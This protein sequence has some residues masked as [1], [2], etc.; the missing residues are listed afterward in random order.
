[1]AYSEEALAFSQIPTKDQI[2]V[3]D[4]ISFLYLEYC[5]IRQDRTG[6]VAIGRDYEDI[7]SHTTDIPPAARIQLPV[8]GLGVLLLGPGTSISN[9]AATSC[10]RSG[11]SIMFTSGG[12]I[13]C[14]SLGTP[15]TSSAKWA[16]AQAKLIANEARARDAA[17]IL[18]RKQLGIA[19]MNVDSIAAM[20]GIE[21][22]TIR[23]LYK[24]LAS[25]HK[26]KRFKRDTNSND[27]VNQGLNLANSILYGCAATACGALGINPA[28]GII[29]R[30]DINSLLFD[31]ADI[32]K[33]NISIP[34][35][36]SC[37]QHE[38]FDK[39]YAV[40]LEN[41]STRTKS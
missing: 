3:E 1:M 31:L 22:R 6:V 28:L 34:L 40:K 27:P 21:G 13:N 37:A 29:H 41:V 30:G 36:F 4:R 39:K 26:I 20:R 33:P 7:T 23:S 9:P 19:E 16:I 32:Y 35:A 15:L 8:A 2:R 18:Y 10:A 11:V 25:Q 38:D 14:Y 5:L 17:R 24:R 12:G